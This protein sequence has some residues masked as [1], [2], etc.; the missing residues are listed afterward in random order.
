MLDLGT[1]YEQQ[2]SANIERNNQVMQQLGLSASIGDALGCSGDSTDKKKKSADE[3]SD[4]SYAP[5]SES[6]DD[7]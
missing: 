6:E 3:E 7:M 2:R 4:D 1:P 5:S